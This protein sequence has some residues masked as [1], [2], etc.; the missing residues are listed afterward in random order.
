MLGFVIA[1]GSEP[2]TQQLDGQYGGC[3]DSW[4]RNHIDVSVVP[5]WTASTVHTASAQWCSPICHCVVA[6]MVSGDH[7]Q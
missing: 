2:C 4:S 6:W 5:A 3:T 1:H 7:H